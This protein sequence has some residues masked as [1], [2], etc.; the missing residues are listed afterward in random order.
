MAELRF[1]RKTVIAAV[2]VMEGALQGHADLTREFLKFGDELNAKCNPGS[3]KDRFNHLIKFYIA[4]PEGTTDDGQLLQDAIVERAASLLP[5][6]DDFAEAPN[7][8]DKQQAFLR[9]LSLDGFT[10][11][12]RVIHAALPEVIG[13]PQAQNDVFRLLLAH[14]FNT[15]KGHLDQAL[16][17]HATGNWAAA[18]SQLRSFFEGLLDE[19][20]I[21]L[22]ST[23]EFLATSENRRAKLARD[24]FIYV[25]F[26]EWHDRGKGFIQ[27]LWNRLHPSGSHPGLSDEDDSTFR[28][29]I[30]LLTTRLL[31]VRFDKLT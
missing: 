21:K 12:E 23:A 14:G 3:L 1:S 6:T 13:L 31:L 19:I 18:N 20:A 11:N 5:L 15:P 8:T 16:E 9:A 24:G 22:D 25:D 2:E 4:D 26:N 30:V 17:N 27:G 10:V 7:Y 29:H 28:L